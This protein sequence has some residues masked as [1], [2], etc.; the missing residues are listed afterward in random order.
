MGDWFMGNSWEVMGDSWKNLGKPW[1]LWLK[2]VGNH[3]QFLPHLDPSS[4]VG[5]DD[6]VRIS[7]KHG[8]RKEAKTEKW[9]TM[10]CWDCGAEITMMLKLWANCACSKSD[11]T[12]FKKLVNQN[13]RRHTSD[14]FDQDTVGHRRTGV[15]VQRNV[16]YK[17]FLTKCELDLGV[18]SSHPVT[19]KTRS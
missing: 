8:S 4:P 6:A 9:S 13:H 15:S 7:K 18:K 14:C 12:L 10:I 16:F 19:I 5:C 2:F 11:I 1:S 17:R 3:G